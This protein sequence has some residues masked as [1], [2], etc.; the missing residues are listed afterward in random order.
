MS[1]RDIAWHQALHK[2]LCLEQFGTEFTDIMTVLPQILPYV[3]LRRK[4]R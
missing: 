2:S 4:R 1:T 3:T